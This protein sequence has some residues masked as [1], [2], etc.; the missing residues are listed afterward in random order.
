MLCAPRLTEHDIG[1]ANVHVFMNGQLIFSDKFEDT[2]ATG[3][4]VQYSQGREG[5]LSIGQK[6][7]LSCL[8]FTEK[9]GHQ[10]ALAGDDLSRKDWSALRYS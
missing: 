10:A 4:V 6:H 7:K 3:V 9:A 2:E 8:S 1:N 5:P